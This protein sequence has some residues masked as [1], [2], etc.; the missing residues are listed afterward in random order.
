MSKQAV[1]V[2]GPNGWASLKDDLE[3]AG[4]HT[5]LG[6]HKQWWKG[7]RFFH[8]NGFVYEI[9]SAE[10]DRPLG[11]ISKILASTLY[12]P[13]LRL[14]YSYR[15]VAE[16]SLEQ[17]RTAVANAIRQDD[18]VLTQFEDEAE[19]LRRLS[20]ADSFPA[21]AEVIRRGVHG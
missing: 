7:V 9:E 1:I 3:I 4:R 15:Q 5:T 10:P 20:A 19:L 11:K 16:Y 21:V 6:Y 12:N 2:V 18:D 17:L 8:I 14:K 13:W